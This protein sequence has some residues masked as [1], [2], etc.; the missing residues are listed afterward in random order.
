RP[1][2]RTMS[3]GDFRAPINSL[4]MYDPAL[5]LSASDHVY[6]ESYDNRYPKN[7]RHSKSSG[8]LWPYRL[9]SRLSQTR[10]HRFYE[11]NDLDELPQPP[12]PHSTPRISQAQP[13][14]TLPPMHSLYPVANLESLS[15]KRNSL[16]GSFESE[17]EGGIEMSRSSSQQSD[18]RYNPS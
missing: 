13:R 11:L 12:T 16:Y 4:H 18:Y 2:I 8:N 17:F 3:V 10:L 5:L 7:L 15:V 14:Q 1:P 9:I 6:Q